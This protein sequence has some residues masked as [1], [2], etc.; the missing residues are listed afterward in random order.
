[1]VTVD[2]EITLG[3]SVVWKL[4]YGSRGTFPGKAY[5]LN[6]WQN[7]HRKILALERLP[8]KLGIYKYEIIMI[9]SDDI[10]AV[11]VI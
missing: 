5:C 10:S 9:I 7:T 6:T 8:F 1:M 11:E 2:L 3:G 4:A